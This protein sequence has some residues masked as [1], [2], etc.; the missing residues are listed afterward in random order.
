[1]SVM[2]AAE[3]GQTAGA[4][5]KLSPRGP[6]MARSVS[7]PDGAEADAGLP[8]GRSAQADPPPRAEHDRRLRLVTTEV[9]VT[10]VLVA[11]E[12]STR[13]VRAGGPET[14][15][16]WVG[17]PGVGMSARGTPRADVPRAGDAGVS[18]PGPG[19]PRVS[20][21]WPGAPGVSAQRAS[22][23]RTSVRHVAVPGAS[24]HRASVHRASAER[25]AEPGAS[26]QRV[27]MQRASVGRV[28]VQAVAVPAGGLRLTRRG[29]RVLTGFVMLVI[30]ISAMLIWTSVA[31]AQ[32]PSAGSAARSPYQGMTQIVV[33]PGQTL[34]SVAAAA[35]PSADPWTVI[36]Q[37]SDANALNGAQIQAGQLLWVPTG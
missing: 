10:E 13:T 21:P 6:R 36:Q 27:R 28:S 20:A 23:Q 8:S 3:A 9:H 35:E 29:R 16:P 24:A 5:P 11:R 4:C 19:A 25:V 17:E 32:A 37:I 1:M 26:A 33:Q 31:G 18:G 15:A 30:I 7:D 22:V 14:G 2:S 12:V 34:W